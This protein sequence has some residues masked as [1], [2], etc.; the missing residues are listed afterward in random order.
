MNKPKGGV[1]IIGNNVR[2]KTGTAPPHSK[3]KASGQEIEPFPDV[4]KK[5]VKKKETTGEYQFSNPGV[6]YK[7]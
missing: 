1:K 2:Q 5:K 4:I 3:L 6:L 7:K